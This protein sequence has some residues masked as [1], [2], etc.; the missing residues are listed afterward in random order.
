MDCPQCENILEEEVLIC[1][2]CGFSVQRTDN[3]LQMLSTQYAETERPL[4]PQGELTREFKPPLPIA[5]KPSFRG[6]LVHSVLGEGAMGSAYLASHLILQMPLV[7]KTFKTAEHWNVFNEAHLAARV[8]SPN[9]VGVIDA[10]VEKGVPFVIQR[11]MDGI[12]LAELI[13]FMQEGNWHLPV[14]TVCLILI[15]AAKGLH[16]IHQAGV[17]HRDV[18]PA[19]LFLTGYGVTTVGDFGIAVDSARTKEEQLISGT[20]LF[21]PPEQWLQSEVGRYTDI[22]ALGATGH[23]LLTGKPPFEGRTRGELASAHIHQSYQPPTKTSPAEAYLF[24][25]IERTLRKKT[26]ERYQTGEALCRVLEVVAEPPPQ[27]VCTGQDE[28]RV[29]PLQIELTVGDLSASEGDV[30]VNAA[31]S[32]MVMDLGVA[33]ALKRVAGPEVEVEAMEQ[34][35]IPMGG[36]I[37][38]GAGNLKAR[39][40]AHAVSAMSGAVCLQRCTLRTLLGAEIRRAKLIVFPALGTGVGDVPMELAAKLTL[41]AIRTF[42]SFQPKYV[43]NIRI[44]L[45]TNSGL[46]RW[47]MILRSI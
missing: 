35:P 24:S 16:A 12:D 36:V 11:Y 19:N 37:W 9:V 30:L 38:T 5:D 22:Y 1:N 6:L 10:G 40:L 44:V 14:N 32:E 7:I 45:L 8:V 20:P 18:K 39:W 47:R 28:A 33:A 15:D 25:V 34:A 46:S 42:A 26:E 43:Q 17:I 2:F 27:I 4:N 29:G 13:K 41:E 23:L 3:I 31:N 21:M